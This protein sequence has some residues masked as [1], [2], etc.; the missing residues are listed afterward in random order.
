LLSYAY[1]IFVFTP[2]G[3]IVFIH[4]PLVFVS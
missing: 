2:M 1:Y 4:V 3:A